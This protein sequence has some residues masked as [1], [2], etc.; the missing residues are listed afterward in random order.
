MPCHRRFAGVS[1]GGIVKPKL[2]RNSSVMII[3]GSSHRQCSEGICRGARVKRRASGVATAER[4]P[5]TI[6]GRLPR[7]RHGCQYPRMPAIYYGS[8]VAA[9]GMYVA[10]AVGILCRSLV[11]G[12]VIRV[13]SRESWRHERGQGLDGRNAPGW[14]TSREPRDLRAPYS[15]AISLLQDK[16]VLE[17]RVVSYHFIIRS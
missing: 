15:Q 1:G 3:A 7:G 6:S 13:M 14:A 5:N 9:T 11:R 4:T 12:R 8:E 10:P 2:A 16:R 17:C